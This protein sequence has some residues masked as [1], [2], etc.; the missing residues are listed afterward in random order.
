MEVSMGL[1][2]LNERIFLKKKNLNEAATITPYSVA[3][4]R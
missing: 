3:L 4:V 2:I 1:Q